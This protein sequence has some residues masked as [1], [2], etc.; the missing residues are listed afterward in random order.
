MRAYAQRQQTAHS[1]R[2]TCFLARNRRNGSSSNQGGSIIGAWCSGRRGGIGASSAWQTGKTT[3]RRRAL[4]LATQQHNDNGS[5]IA[6]IASVIQH[7]AG[8]SQLSP[9]IAQWQQASA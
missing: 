3:A 6:R 7:A 8:S 2:E 4:S 5:S 9:G 1:L